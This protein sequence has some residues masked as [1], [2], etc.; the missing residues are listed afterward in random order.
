VRLTDTHVSAKSEIRSTSTGEAQIGDTRRIGPYAVLDSGV[1]AAS[2]T[3]AGPFYNS[4]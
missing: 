1:E 2:G 4:S 3:V